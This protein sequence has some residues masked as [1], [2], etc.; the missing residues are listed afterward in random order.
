MLSNGIA[1]GRS[2]ASGLAAAAAV[3]VL[4]A[5]GAATPAASQA[6]P[7]DIAA[8]PSGDVVALAEGGIE[9]ALASLP[10]IVAD[11]KARSGV[12]GIAVA[13]VHGGETVFAE[14]YGVRKAGTDAPVDADT[15]FQIASLSKPIAGTVA[16]IQVTA[17][18]LAWDDEV[19]RYLPSL[20][21]ADPY[22]TANA[23]VG[24]F[25]S[26][27]SGLP[28]GAGDDLE[29]IGFDRATIISRLG[30]LP[31]DAF[32]TSYHYANFGLTIGGEAVAAASG[33][34]WA[35][36][37]Q[38]ALFGPL[39][40]SATSYRY[41]DF[42]AH[43]NRTALHALVDGELRPLYERHPDAQAPAGGASSSVDDLAKWLSLLL[44]GGEHEG[45]AMISEAALVPALRAQSFS[46]PTR[47]L[48]LR[49]SF[50]GYGF[51]VSTNANGRLAISHSGAFVLGAGTNMQMLPS[52]DVAIVV[53]TNGGPIGAAEAIA[54][55][56]MDLVQFGETT[57]DWFAGYNRLLL[58]YYDPIGDLVGETAP[59]N[60]AAARPLADYAGSY[61]N[62]YFGPA[63]IRAEGD[64]LTFVLGPEGAVELPLTVWGGD[65]FAVAPRNE[66][67]PDGSLSSVTFTLEEGRATGFT[68]QYLDGHGLGTWTR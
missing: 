8:N 60:A 2:I 54:S 13:V 38:D 55:Q 37:A 47:S 68:V 48:D 41:A 63:Q 45:E 22:V 25:F 19:S 52:A 30:Q 34:T 11:I 15:V 31:L 50:Y 23:T 18:V 61:R 62:S 49:S 56:F 43:E 16:A 59:A 3:V 24:D 44:A 40:M 7:L 5:T 9:T 6:I 39:G 51:G 35:Q 1:R 57:R 27:R 65:T 66:N 21:L 32:R 28:L 64:A 33:T 67:A 36:V 4:G 29:D 12:P 20:T 53:L 26:H 10:H 17:G 58:S 42:V 46:G 14:G